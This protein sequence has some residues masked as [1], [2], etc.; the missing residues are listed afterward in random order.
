MDRINTYGQSCLAGI[1]ALIVHVS[2]LDMF[3]LISKELSGLFNLAL[4][5][6]L[7]SMIAF[8]MAFRLFSGA[9]A[10]VTAFVFAFGVLLSSP[11]LVV[12]KI[13]N[14]VSLQM[15]VINMFFVAVPA[16]VIAGKAWREGFIHGWVRKVARDIVNIKLAG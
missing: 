4:N 15:M 16:L 9:S 13:G 10:A 12:E 3:A 14:G 11:V 5:S 2:F 7:F 8:F 6:A 1:L